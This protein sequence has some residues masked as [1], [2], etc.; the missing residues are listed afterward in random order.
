[1]PDIPVW[2]VCNINC[3]FCSNP[4]EYRRTARH[5]TFD[6]FKKKWEM[7]LKGKASYHKFNRVDDYI[8]LTGGEPTLHPE[9]LKI[10]ALLR[11]SWPDRKIKLLT[12]ARL[13]RYPDFTKK[14]LFIGGRHLEIGV[15]VFGYDARTYQAIS[16]TP[17]AFEDA[18]AGFANI[19]AFRLP[20]QLVGV[21]I[22][23]HKII[24][25][26]LKEL[27]D[28]LY[29]HYPGIDTM[30]LI[31]TEF[32][33]AAAANFDVLKVKMTEVGKCLSQLRSSLSRFREFRLLHFPL[34]AVPQELWPNVWN[35]LDTLKIVHAPSCRHCAA[36]EHC[37]GIHR[38]Y[39]DKMGTGEFKPV[40]T[41]E[42]FIFS[43]FRYHPVL[44]RK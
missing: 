28:Y 5:Y 30:E 35:T 13:L 40:K 6:V 22:I 23:L 20:G 12:N 17:G 10:L 24:L 41:L 42:N 19:M 18:Q 3:V 9:F 36:L 8:G 1:M 34:C 33:G 37:V 2:P 29:C 38:T 15:P 26:W 32:E 43:D 27:L 21:R 14:V 44:G 39:A 7:Y 4:P 16:R 25:R 11:K 31:Y